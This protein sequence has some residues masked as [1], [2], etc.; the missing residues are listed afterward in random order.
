MAQSGHRHPVGGDAQRPGVGLHDALRLAGGARG[1]QDVGRVVGGDGRRSF[2]DGG[3]VGVGRGR[4]EVVPGD[5]PLGDGVAGPRA[6]DHD[7]GRQVGEVDARGGERGDV[8]DPEE[9]GDGHQGPG[10]AAADDVDGLGALEP[11]VDRDERGARFP[12][13]EGG[14]D[15]AHAVGRPDRHPVAG[16]DARRDQPG[17]EGPGRVLQLGEAQRHVA[18]DD[19]GG[20]GVALGRRGQ[21][22]GDRRGVERVGC[23]GGRGRHAAF[24]S[25]TFISRARL[26]PMILR[27]DS[28]GRPCSSFR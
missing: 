21:Q 10:A 25:S 1:E 22:A 23:S 2:G 19:G 9:V 12:Q 28:S 27:T 5:G 18:V 15:P 13:A 6:G 24:V 20:V 4:V 26:P 17:A 11:G 8:V 7:R 16:L 3:P 14:D